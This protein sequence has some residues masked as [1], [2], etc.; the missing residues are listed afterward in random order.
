MR[1]SYAHLCDYATFGDRGK[2]ILVG[3]FGHVV[4]VKNTTGLPVI[5]VEP[6]YFVFCLEGTSAEIGQHI[7]T[8]RLLDADGEMI[9][10]YD[11]PIFMADT[12]DAGVAPESRF[13][14]QIQGLALPD[15]GDYVW[16]LSCGGERLGQLSL[17]VRELKLDPAIQ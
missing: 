10:K 9:A 7:I 5:P 8:V 15:F 1:L 2:P 3:I 16:E 14:V 6:F 13:F 4:G 17:S 11:V 12:K